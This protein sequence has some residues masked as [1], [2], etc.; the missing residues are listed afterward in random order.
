M[1][2]VLWATWL[3]LSC[4]VV[5]AGVIA[6]VRALRQPVPARQLSDYGDFVDVDG[7]AIHVWQRGDRAGV[8]T[9]IILVHGF[10]A[11]N[12]GWRHTI[13]PLSAHR[14]VLA[15]D[16][17][18]FGL[19]DKPVGF[20]YSL[21]GYARFIVDL[22]DAMGIGEAVLVG[23]SMG[24]G[25]AVKAAYLFPERIRRLVLID[26]LGYY[27]RSFQLYRF[28]GLPIVGNLVMGMAGPRSIGLL[29]RA[30]V[31][32]DPSR[33]DDRTAHRFAIAYGTENGRS[34]PIWVYRGLAPSPT[35]GRDEIGAVR[36]PTLVIWGEN[37]KILPAA[38]AARFGA[39]IDGSITV[40]LP[41]TGHVPHEER[42]EAVNRLILDFVGNGP[43]R[44]DGALKPVPFGLK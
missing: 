3:L 24:G 10:G 29:L 20:D 16:L 12:W 41:E 7:L 33:L 44:P 30:R 9:P 25:V 8:G 43:D 11:S 23:N 6:L 13:G 34:A 38:H 37:D 21:S 26:S 19:S 35:I 27:R 17:P 39:D 28:L 1:H 32:H 15:P 18:G 36:V 22:M 31:Y 2:Q 4:A 5:L 42:P 40:V 14:W